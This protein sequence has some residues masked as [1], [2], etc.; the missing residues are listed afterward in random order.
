MP[1][2]VKKGEG[3]CQCRSEEVGSRTWVVRIGQNL[4]LAIA[5]FITPTKQT[6]PLKS[7]EENWL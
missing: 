3:I 1:V 4:V 6:L 2:R 5:A 7:A